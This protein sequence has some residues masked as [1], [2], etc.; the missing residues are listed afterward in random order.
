MVICYW[1]SYVNYGFML[2]IYYGS[3]VNYIY[4][5]NFSNYVNQ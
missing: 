1:I 5:V 4:H 2:V 3:Y